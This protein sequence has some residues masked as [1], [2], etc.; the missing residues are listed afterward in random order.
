MGWQTV[1]TIPFRVDT[2]V[3]PA[4]AAAIRDALLRRAVPLGRMV[5]GR[6][7]P[8]AT[9]SLIEDGPWTAL[10]TAAHILERANIGDLVVPLPNDHR[11]LLLRSARVRVIVHPQSDLAM[12]GF[13]DPAIARRLAENWVAFPLRQWCSGVRP[14]ARAYAIAGYPV[15]NTRRAEGCVVVKPVVVLSC[16]VGA[17]CYAYGRTATRVDGQEI[18]TPEL[19]GVS[20]ATVWAVDD[21]APDGVSCVLRPA[22]VQVAFQHSRHFRGEPIGGAHAMLA[23]LH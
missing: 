6:L 4:R 8:L 9:A 21:E 12:I 1:D 19:D 14:N 18:H 23:W 7:E 16:V 13:I 10:L 22:A 5:D 2:D 15:A 11:V 17:D 20:G 3:S